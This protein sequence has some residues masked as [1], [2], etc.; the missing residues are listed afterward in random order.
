MIRKGANGITTETFYF[1]NN[2]EDGVDDKELMRIMGFT[3]FDTTKDKQVED[4]IA[5]AAVG[6]VS[7]NRRRIY[8][9]YMNR[10]GGF[11]RPLQKLA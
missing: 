1:Q 8:R 3:G 6:A 5:G 10:R 11:N 2:G 9:Q 4:N 7:K